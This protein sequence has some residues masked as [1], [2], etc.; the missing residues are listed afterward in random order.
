MYTNIWS[1]SL[2][3]YCNEKENYDDMACKLICAAELLL[4]SVARPGLEL[5][6]NLKFFRFHLILFEIR[7]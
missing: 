2:R 4:K 7:R 6:I 1:R 3:F 5:Q